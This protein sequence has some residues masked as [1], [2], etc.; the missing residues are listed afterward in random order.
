VILIRPR[1]LLEHFAVHPEPDVEPLALGL[2]VDV[3]RLRANGATNDLVENEDG[4]LL[5]NVIG[6]PE[7]LTE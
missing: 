6:H 3:A 1:P 7:R 2:E 5:E 4:A